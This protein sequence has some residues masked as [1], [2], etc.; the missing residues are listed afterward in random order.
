MP[1]G[2]RFSRWHP[3]P[4]RV[5]LAV[6]V[7][8]LVLAGL[9]HWP[10]ATAPSKNG[11][12]S[13]DS[14]S[15]PFRDDDLPLYDRIIERVAAGDSYYEAAIEEQRARNFPVRPALAVRL[16]TLAIA[17]AWLGRPGLYAAGGLLWLGLLLAWWRRLGEEPG[18]SERRP[19]A[20]LLLVVGTA[21]GLKPSYFP[22]HE[23]WAGALLAL[24]FALHGPSRWAGAVVAAAAA[25]AI[26]EHALPFVLLMGAVALWHRKWKELAAWTGVA[27]AFAAGLLAHLA[28]VTASLTPLDRP[29]PPWLVLRG[30]EGFTTDV[31]LSSVLYLLPLA[32]A[33]PIALLPL[34]GWAG[35]RSRAGVF[36]TLL[37]GGYAVFLMLAG[38]ENNFYWALMITPAYFIGLAF[39]P[40][41]V[42]S[43]A[44][45]ARGR[46]DAPGP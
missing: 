15:G 40:A 43:L 36:G 38:R 33:A 39:V 42:T 16:P 28:A 21:I 45:A 4:A 31:V 9:T 17:S 34:I 10:E 29:S 44:R 37:F 22:L 26:R 8:L 12:A 7:V 23:V 2:G 25:L 13:A 6:I 41:A 14:S 27:A 24:S 32:L 46:S 11:P 30:L 19:I 3:V 1:E 20:M 18:G 35:W 5:M